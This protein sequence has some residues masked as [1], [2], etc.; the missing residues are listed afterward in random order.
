V[1]AQLESLYISI[2]LD[3]LM[4]L[5]DF[6]ISGLPTAAA[7][8]IEAAKVPLEQQT[9]AITDG[10]DSD[11]NRPTTDKKPAARPSK[12]PAKRRTSFISQG[13]LHLRCDL[14][15][16]PTSVDAEVETRI[17]VI[18]KNPQIILLEDQHNGNSNC[19]VL[20][21]SVSPLVITRLDEHC[22][23]WLSKCA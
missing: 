6:F 4:T 5:Q 1:N 17:D 8:S 9:S 23:S 2:S 3:Y 18:I 16:A 10:P 15:S 21:V 13:M 12:A 22:S 19:L 14:Y 7:P 20:D 11:T